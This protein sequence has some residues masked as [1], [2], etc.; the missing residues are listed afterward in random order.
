ML[1]PRCRASLPEG[2]AY[3]IHCGQP[4]AAYPP[5]AAPPAGGYP[6]YQP[7]PYNPPGSSAY[8]HPY[9][10]PYQQPVYPASGRLN[11]PM[12]AWS[13]VNLFFFTVLG[14]VALGLTISAKEEWSAAE[15]QKKLR[16]AMALNII[17]T[18]LFAAYLVLSFMPLFFR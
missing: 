8:T 18:V 9:G 1:C 2:F 14:A 15:E 7:N 17:G 12:L 10:Y 11:G 5:P 3:C 16:I 4:L 13:I 6:P